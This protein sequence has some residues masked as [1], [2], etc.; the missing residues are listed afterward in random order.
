MSKRLAD[1][2]LASAPHDIPCKRRRLSADDVLI[3]A[4]RDGDATAVRVGLAELSPGSK[5]AFAAVHEACRE[6]HHECT[7]ALLAHIEAMQADFDSLLSQCI[8]AGGDRL[9][10]SPLHSAC[11]EGTLNVVKLLVGAG[12]GVCV[13]DEEGNTCLMLALK[14]GH[15]ETV[16]YL[17]SLPEIDVTETTTALRAAVMRKDAEVVQVLIDAGADVVKRFVSGCAPLDGDTPLCAAIGQGALDVVKLLVIAGAGVCVAGEGGFTCL[18]RASLNGHTETV[19]YLLSL[20]EMDVTQADNNGNTALHM[21]ASWKHAEVVQ[22][23]IDAGADVDNRNSDMQTP[24]HLA[25]SEGTL[26]VVKLL[27]RAG[28]GVCVAD[29]EGNTCL[30]FA[31]REGHTEIV[32][33]LLSLPEMDV[34]QADSGGDT[35]WEWAQMWDQV[36]I[37]QVLIDAGADLDKRGGTEMTLLLCASSDGQLDVV[38]LL[39]S[40]GAS[41]CITDDIGAT[42][43]MIA[44]REGHTEIVRYLLSLPETDVTQADNN[45][46][47]ALHKAASE[48]VVQVLIDAGA[49]VDKRN[50]N[51]DTPL[52][53]AS[54]KGA[55]DVVKLLVRAGAGVCAANEEGNTCLMLASLNGHIDIVR[56][57]VSLPQIDVTQAGT[58]LGLA[59]RGEH[60][61]VARMLFNHLSNIVGFCIF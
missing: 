8:R 3:E 10:L 46:D 18:M 33:Y 52:C 34:T 57:L 23:L 40:S 50:T 56:Y 58:A 2:A 31:S 36:E 15:A 9:S 25:S 24:L 30:M 32:R 59:A 27:V 1:S 54:S 4:A 49:D 38:K 42:C 43:V 45:G 22:V 14:N 21:A 41:V 35:A 28:A 26:D 37:L 47:T 17:V 13:A 53:A 55:L 60:A 48:E 39:V 16:R 29:E 6:G 7:A 44:S 51:G 11:R 20:P 61:E 5:T 19:R 12:A